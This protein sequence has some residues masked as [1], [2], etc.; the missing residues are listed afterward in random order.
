MNDF[1]T[2]FIFW[3]FGNS[4]VMQDYWISPD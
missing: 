2:A 1:V 3:L 4:S